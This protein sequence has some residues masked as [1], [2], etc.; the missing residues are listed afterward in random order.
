MDGPGE[1]VTGAGDSGKRSG[2]GG[3]AKKGN[4]NATEEGTQAQAVQGVGTA[5]AKAG[6]SGGAMNADATRE[7]V[8]RNR[9]DGEDELME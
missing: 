5:A 6:G 4:A 1:S 7:E 3:K 9:E 8:A 2:K